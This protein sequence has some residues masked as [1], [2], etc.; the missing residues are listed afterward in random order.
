MCAPICGLVLS[1]DCSFGVVLWPGWYSSQECQKLHWI[2][3][4]RKECR[5]ATKEKAEKKAK[6]KAAKKEK[7]MT[8]DAVE[9]VE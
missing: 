2:A 6:K 9:E 3:G 4:H 8:K 5:Q 7:K 1:A